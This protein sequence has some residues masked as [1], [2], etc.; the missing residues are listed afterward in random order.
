[1]LTFVPLVLLT[2]L[3]YVSG[4]VIQRDERA[5]PTT[6]RSDEHSEAADA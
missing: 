4:R 2:T 3:T 1:V 5:G 6:E